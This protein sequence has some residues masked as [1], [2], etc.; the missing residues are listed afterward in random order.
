MIDGNGTLLGTI[1]D[2]DLR[3]NMDT[4][5]SMCAKDVMTLNPQVIS[6]TSLLVK[7]L[8]VMNEK[9]ITCLFIVEKNKPIGILHIHDCLRAGLN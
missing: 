7:S 9:E 1:T 6:P 2:G 3:R 8:E 4:L 5:L